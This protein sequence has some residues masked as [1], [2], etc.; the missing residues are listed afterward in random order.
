MTWQTGSNLD[1]RLKVQTALGSAATGASGESLRVVKGSPGMR[2]LNALI[3]SNE[4]R[5]DGMTIRGRHGSGRA[6]GSY[7]CEVSLDSFDTPFEA[8]T[9]GTW[10]AEATRTYDNSAGLTS[11]E[12]T[13]TGEITQVGTTTLIGAVYQGDRI[14]L[15]GMSNAANND[16]W[17]RVTN[18]TATII[19]V[20][21]APLTV[22]IADIACTL[23]VARKLVSADPPTERYFTV[24]QYNTDIDLSEYFTDVKFTGM[25]FQKR[26]DSPIL[27]T[28]TLVGLDGGPLATGSSPTLTDPTEFTTRPLVM[29]DGVV[30]IGG[31]DYTGVTGFDLSIDNRATV[32]EVLAANA[33]DVF[34]GNQRVSGSFTTLITD[35]DHFTAAKAET[36]QD[37]DIQMN[38]PDTANPVDFLGLYLGDVVLDSHDA[39]LG[40]D[41][42]R[43]A[44][45]NFRAGKD[46][47]GS[48]RDATI[49]KL[50]TSAT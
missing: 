16:V 24:E 50:T 26:P 36:Q 8:V 9:R 17:C 5:S 1:V 41:G 32:P 33:P 28:F 4:L 49:V 21:G 19:T 29:A 18:V 27:V 44:T 38:E 14:K 42:P 46:E 6:E 20:A 48:D 30:R 13:G 15:A 45:V 25:R 7:N 39:P 34:S 22:Q 37:I 3:E 31:T 43:I 2:F 40:E 35:F 10:A 23:T 11:L 47:G 12:V